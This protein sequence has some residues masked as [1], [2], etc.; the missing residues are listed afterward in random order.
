MSEKLSDPKGQ[1]NNVVE[2]E[3]YS[4]HGTLSP[5]LG[6]GDSS[7]NSRYSEESVYTYETVKEG[8]AFSRFI[9]SFKPVNLEE[10]GIDTSGM[11]PTEKSI[12]ASARHPLARRLK[13]RHLQ[14]IAIGGSIGT[15]LFIGSGYALASGGPAGV[16]IGYLLIGYCMLCV[17]NALGELS[18]QFPVSGSFNAFFTRF[19][20]PSVGFTLGIL[21]AVSWLVSFPSE[22]IAC[23]MTVQYWNSLINPAVWVAIFY[24]VIVAIN[25][26]GVK[27]YGEAEFVLSMIKVIAVVGFLILG[28]CII[29]GVGTQ[30]YIGGKYWHDPGAFNHGF[31]GVCSVF[32]SAAF[33]FGGIELVALAAAETQNPR[34]SLP[35]ATKQVFWRVTI[36]YVLTAIIIGCLVPY[37]NDQLLNGSSSE[38]ITASPFVIAIKNGGIRV[39]PHIMNAVILVAV[40]SVGN[41]SVYGCSRTLASLAVQG[42]IPSIFGFIDRAG[43]PMF[44]IMFTNLFGLLGFIV[45]NQNQSDVFTW[46]FSICSLSSFF[47][48]GMICFTH[49]RWRWALHAQGRSK[50]EIIFQSPLDIW[51]SL[52]GIAILI[53]VVG[54]EIWVSIWPIGYPADV[55]T[56]WQNCLSLPLLIVMIIAHKT[57]IRNW[58]LFMINLVDIDLDTGRRE[59]DIEGLKQEI[60][61]DRE[62]LSRKPFWYKI[63]AIFC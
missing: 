63:Y 55:V 31:K 15:G 50:D 24:V 33:S 10:E 53:F 5:S 56:F 47:T 36:F 34:R 12:I 45:V 48:W 2:S 14:M 9:D 41:S 44:A 59:I 58:K 32:I 54:G 30:G 51:G 61:D 11:T 43:R 27:G 40:V 49:L 57:Y 7:A 35:K 22:L 62:A 16:L 26:F 18:V 8:T 29:C 4:Y 3:E 6:H 52:S 19:V 20:D 37:N 21:Y 13:L 23:S 60:A 28:V 17:V 38:D 42:L 25:L 1:P 46:F 39:V